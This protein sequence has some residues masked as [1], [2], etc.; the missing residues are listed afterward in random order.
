MKNFILVF[1]QITG[2]DSEGDESTDA[3]LF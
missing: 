2:I 1:Q 3:E